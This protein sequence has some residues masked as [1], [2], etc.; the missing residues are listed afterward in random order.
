MSLDGIEKLCEKS[1]KQDEIHI[2]DNA[3][4]SKLKVFPEMY[5]WTP[6]QDYFEENSR[7]DYFFLFLPLTCYCIDFF[8]MN[9]RHC[10]E[11]RNHEKVAL[12]M[13]AL[14]F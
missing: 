2:L 1:Q 11:G 3:K 13:G 4:T 14:K 12:K 7:F 8:V 10:V 6:C 5:P 9:F